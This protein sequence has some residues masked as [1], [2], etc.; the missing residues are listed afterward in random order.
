MNRRW[1][2]AAMLGFCL[3]SCATIFPPPPSGVSFQSTPP[4]AR[5]WVNAVLVGHTPVVANISCTAP[6]EVFFSLEG[7]QSFSQEIPT[8]S[9]WDH[10]GTLQWPAD[11]C[12]PVVSVHLAPL[13]VKR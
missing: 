11:F 5:V 6:Q 10:R 12:A 7:Y 9:G 4:G 2:S 1:V 13:A 3:T 8:V